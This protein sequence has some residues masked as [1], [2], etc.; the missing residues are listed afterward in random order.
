MDAT[1]RTILRDYRLGNRTEAEVRRGF[2]RAGFTPDWL[3]REVTRRLHEALVDDLDF[4]KLTRLLDATDEAT[5]FAANA[6]SNFT[7]VRAGSHPVT[8]N[9]L[10][11]YPSWE[12]VLAADGNFA[13]IRFQ[14]N[15]PIGERADVIEAIG[16]HFPAARIVTTQTARV[17]KCEGRRPPRHQAPDVYAVRLE[18]RARHGDDDDAAWP[19][20]SNRVHIR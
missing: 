5:E 8:V 17:L 3:T 12:E 13:D 6:S 9:I 16:E 1:L 7:A 18:R 19:Q 11:W 15:A 10:A 20:E 2:Q 14:V 4:V